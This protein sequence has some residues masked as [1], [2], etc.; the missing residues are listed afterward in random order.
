MKENFKE[1]VKSNPK[2]IDYVKNKKG[3]WQELYEIYSI[4][5]EDENIWNKYINEDK[6]INELINIIK[7]VNL[8]S[9]KTTVD[10]LQKV[11]S[12]LQNI[13]GKK[14]NEEEYERTRKYENLDD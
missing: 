4:Y 12:I 2:I 7:N 8:D 5:G 1:F 13:S 6:G 14:D 10:G 11:V 3:T 9:I